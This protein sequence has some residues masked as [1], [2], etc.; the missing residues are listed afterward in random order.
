MKTNHFR[1]A[2]FITKLYFDSIYQRKNYIYM[3][4]TTVVSLVLNYPTNNIY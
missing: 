2:K 4:L 1:E 3:Y